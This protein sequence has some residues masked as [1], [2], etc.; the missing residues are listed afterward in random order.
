MRLP[1][2]A[3]ASVFTLFGCDTDY[4]KQMQ[5]NEKKIQA[6]ARID[7]KTGIPF[8]QIADA[9]DY[10]N[11]N[12]GVKGCNLIHE[13]VKDISTTRSSCQIDQRTTLCKK[14]IGFLSQHK[15]SALLPKADAI[16]LPTN[17]VYWELPTVMLESLAGPGNYRT[18]VTVLWWSKWK[19]FLIVSGVLFVAITGFLAWWH[20][21]ATSKAA[22]ATLAAEKKAKQIAKERIR[23]QEL[24]AARIEA[25]QQELLK[26]E[27]AAAE[28]QHIQAE[29]LKRQ[30]A[31]SA[32]ARLAAEQSEAAYI[33]EIAF[34]CATPK[35]KKLK[36]SELSASIS[37]SKKS[38][39]R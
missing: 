19:Y 22:L 14:I 36:P 34:K 35:Q 24:E 15:I 4:E 11:K 33:L 21:L 5:A 12:A 32:A 10:C 26:S 25:E 37:N 18:E 27:A 13:Q 31:A 6:I 3:I 16:A 2:L 23:R 30:E 20:H 7:W 1:I 38:V 29:Q 8:D 9:K 17:P 28:E 39:D